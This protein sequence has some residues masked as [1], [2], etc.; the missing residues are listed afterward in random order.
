MFQVTT[1]NEAHQ[2]VVDRHLSSLEMLH[3]DNDYR[4]VSRIR[5]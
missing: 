2:T 1:V 5:C 3:C 4:Y